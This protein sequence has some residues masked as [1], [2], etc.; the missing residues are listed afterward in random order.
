[1]A[2]VRDLSGNNSF[3]DE[4]IASPEEER[5]EEQMTVLETIA[6]NTEPA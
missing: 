6:T 3:V 1:M 4:H 5:H 2:I